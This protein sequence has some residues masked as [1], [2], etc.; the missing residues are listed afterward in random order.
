MLSLP[1]HRILKRA[2]GSQRLVRQNCDTEQYIYVALALDITL[3]LLSSRTARA[4]MTRITRAF[5]ENLPSHLQQ[6]LG[7]SDAGI[8]N[9]IDRFVDIMYMQTPLIIIDGNMTD[10]ANPACHH[11][12]VWSGTFNPL[13]HEILLN[14]QL[15]EDMVNASESR[16]VLRRFQFQFVN[17]FF[18]EI[19]GHLL[20]TYLYH[21]LPSTPRQVTPP[22]WREQDQEEDIGESGRTLETVVFGGTVEFF[23]IPEARIKKNKTLQPHFFPE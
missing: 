17:L 1:R 19:G 12:D 2:R 22:N 8:A 10:P 13:K 21:G 6:F 9:S 11:R 18:H 23:D 5:D 3:G 20:F 15:V 7:I 14:K 16:Q 4:A